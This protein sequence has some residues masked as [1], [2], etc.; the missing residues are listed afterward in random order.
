MPNAP[1]WDSAEV[2]DAH[3]AMGRHPPIVDTPDI[4]TTVPDAPIIP[5]DL[6]EIGTRLIMA[7]LEIRRLAL[8]VEAMIQPE[9]IDP[10]T[11][12]ALDKWWNS[13]ARPGE[14]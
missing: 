4:V 8:L 11:Q 6:E 7:E 13:R 3:R 14:F 10:I 2:R 12:A 9:P 5:T 1:N